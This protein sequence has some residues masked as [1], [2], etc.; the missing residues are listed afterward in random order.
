MLDFFGYR[1]DHGDRDGIAEL[2]VK[3]NVT[4]GQFEVIWES[5]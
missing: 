4:Q 2:F 1:L 3:V 5:L